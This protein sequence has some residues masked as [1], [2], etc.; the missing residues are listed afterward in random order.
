MDDTLQH[1]GILGMRW[2]VR[3]YQNED[4]TLT[5]AG[6]KRYDDGSQK[7]PEAG[8]SNNTKKVVAGV[9]IGAAAV[10]GAVLTAYLVKK[11]GAKN[12]SD[13][14]DAV[15]AGKATLEKVFES[16]TAASASAAQIP[17]SNVEP[18]K[19][20]EEAVKNVSAANTPRSSIPA[21]SIGASQ[22]YNFESLMRQNQ[23]LL[24]KMYTELL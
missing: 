9:A 18:K 23:S 15:D 5:S 14:T 6:K 7:E 12:L 3:R 1:Y 2:G 8:K 20:I 10:T 16:T 13:M 11:I 21:S 4:G 24:E 19:I 17:Q 22:S